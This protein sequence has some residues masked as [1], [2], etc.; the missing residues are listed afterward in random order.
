ME[1]LIKID[2]KEP[3]RSKLKII[4]FDNTEFAKNI[5]VHDSL[6][7]LFA[8]FIYESDGYDCKDRKL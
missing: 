4:E 1:S 3:K 5:D 8:D 6:K 7:R 2:A